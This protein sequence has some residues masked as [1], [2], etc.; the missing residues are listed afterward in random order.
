MTHNC[1]FCHHP[2]NSGKV[3]AIVSGSFDKEDPKIFN[4]LDTEGFMCEPCSDAGPNSIAIGDTIY[5]V[6]A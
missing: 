3:Y 6:K 5:K 4:S 2:L 1:I